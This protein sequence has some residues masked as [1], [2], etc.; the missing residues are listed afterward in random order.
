LK[1]NVGGYNSNLPDPSVRRPS[2]LDKHFPTMTKRKI[3][4]ILVLGFCHLVF[5]GPAAGCAYA[6]NRRGDKPNIL[7]VL[8]DDQPFHSIEH[9]PAVQEELVRK[10]V[11]FENAYVTTSLCCP[12]RVS[13]LT[14]QYVHH[15]GVLT[16]RAPLGG[17]TVFDDSSTLP[18]WLQQAGYRTALFGKYLNEYNS[19]P[20]GY[21]PPGW[22]EWAAFVSTEPGK[23]FYFGYSL[24][25]NGTIV[26]YGSAQEAYSTD[27]LKEKAVDFIKANSAEPFFLM[28]NVISPHQPYYPAARHANLFKSYTNEFTPYRPPNFFEEDLTDKPSWWSD[29]DPPT[30]DHAEGIYQRI[31]RSLMSTDEAVADLVDTLEKEGIRENTF[32]LF[33]SD[34]GMSLGN[35]QFIGKGCPYDEC[36]RVPYVISY[37]ER[38]RASRTDSN[39]VLNIDIAPTLL[40][41]AGAKEV[42]QIDGV[43][44]LPLLDD[45]T[46][47]IRDG[48]LFEQYGEDDDGE[49]LDITMQVPSYTGFRTNAWNLVL[50]ETGERE[51]YDLLSDPYEMSNLAADSEYSEIVQEL[52][53]RIRE[54]RPE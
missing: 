53:G 24:N 14:G 48:F 27:H 52:T 37:P 22:D 43:S 9:M 40:E 54:I 28:L 23:Y 11:L 50:Y 46:M 32:I 3:L 15:H 17:A 51:L 33:T 38:I 18:V 13:L 34:N 10:G 42:E 30:P 26:Q 20:E 31:L 4:L 12:S 47:R 1:S 8:T 2:I 36:M 7:I 41:L 49:S 16:N 35:H 19:M 39:F 45:P 29:L 6:S 44:L 25:E 5:A 21:I